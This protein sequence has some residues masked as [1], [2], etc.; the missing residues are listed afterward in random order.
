MG[1]EQ[2]R[3]KFHTFSD[4]SIFSHRR[5]GNSILGGQ[6]QWLHLGGSLLHSCSGDSG[7]HAGRGG[8]ENWELGQLTLCSR[9]TGADTHTGR[10][11]RGRS[12]HIEGRRRT[13]CGQGRATGGG[14]WAVGDFDGPFGRWWAGLVLGPL[15]GREKN[16]SC[17]GDTPASALSLHAFSGGPLTIPRRKENSFSP[18]WNSPYL[19]FFTPHMCLLI[20][21]CLFLIYTLHF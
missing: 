17:G 1:V 15:L 14:W 20:Y 6:G 19:C 21:I 10:A 2:G 9:Q 8:Q 11:G 4:P 16:C 7:L 5:A 13:L 12:H 18:H 3:R